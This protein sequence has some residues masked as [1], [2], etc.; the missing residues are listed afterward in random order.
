[1]GNKNILLWVIA[2]IALVLSTI[3]IV[4]PRGQ[5]SDAAYSNLTATQVET[6][7]DDG[8]PAEVSGKTCYFNEG[9]RQYTGTVQGRRRSDG[10]YEWVC[11]TRDGQRSSSSFSV[12]V[13]PS[14]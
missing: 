7:G 10:T 9:T 3:A 6:Y 13:G 1:M 8:L 4:A 14:S 11:V 2:V 5:Q 12:Q